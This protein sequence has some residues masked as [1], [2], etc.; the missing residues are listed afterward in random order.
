LIVFRTE[1]YG[2]GYSDFWL[3]KTDTKG[4]E[5]WNNTYGGLAT[6]LDKIDGLRAD[7]DGVDNQLELGIVFLKMIGN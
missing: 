4:E 7:V 2:A 5:Q 3:V 6:N 1:S